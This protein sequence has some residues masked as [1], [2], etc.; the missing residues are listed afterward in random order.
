LPSIIRYRELARVNSRAK[1]RSAHSHAKTQSPPDK[2]IAGAA[3]ALHDWRLSVDYEGIAWALMDREGERVNS[4][5]RRLIEERGEIVK[6]AE[7]AAIH[8][9]IKGLVLMSAKPTG[10]LVGA[11][12]RE[13]SRFA[14]EAQVKEVVKDAWAVRP[15]RAADPVVAA[16]H[17]FCSAEGS[18][19]PLP[20]S[21][22][23]TRRTRSA[24][25]G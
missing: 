5:G 22:M 23:T 18:S 4:M 20:L 14:T 24:S 10:F 2:D 3:P 7:T 17:G 6:W 21:L 1:C 9:E 16:V 12:I 13:F 25:Q 8:G 15:H 11:D 19:L